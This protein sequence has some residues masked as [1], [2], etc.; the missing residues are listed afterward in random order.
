MTDRAPAAG[1]DARST[2][3]ADALQQAAFGF[4]ACVNCVTHSQ[5]A[6]A[7]WFQKPL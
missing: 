5:I 4:G 1:G 2:A 7:Q 3:V 6:V